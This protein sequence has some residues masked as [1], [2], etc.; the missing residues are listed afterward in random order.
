MKNKKVFC[1]QC[2]KEMINTEA[3]GLCGCG[4]RIFICGTSL[5]KDGEKIR[6]NCGCDNLELI[7]FDDKKAVVVSHYK[8]SNCG[9]EVDAEIHCDFKF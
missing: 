1:M 7:G 9:S 8:C 2:K 6:C 4:S 3:S 5:M